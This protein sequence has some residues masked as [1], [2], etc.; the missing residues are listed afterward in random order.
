MAL[1]KQPVRYAKGIQN[2]KVYSQAADSWYLYD[3]SNAKYRLIAKF[4]EDK[5][6]IY[7]FEVFNQIV[8][9]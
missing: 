8:G 7:H 4:I 5:R 1:E 3:N 6:Q 2:F 9:L